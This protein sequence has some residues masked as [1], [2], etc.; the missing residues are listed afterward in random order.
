MKIDFTD[1]ELRA[2]EYLARSRNYKV[3]KSI[4]E[5]MIADLVDIRNIEGVKNLDVEAAG[6]KRAAEIIEKELL[7]RLK[8]LS[9][10]YEAS[11]PNEYS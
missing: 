5:K 2:M 4:Y 10:E 7:Y 3:W 9:Q 1:K 6:R 11:D 8:S